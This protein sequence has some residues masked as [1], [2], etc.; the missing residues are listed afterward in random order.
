MEI[1]ENMKKILERLK[2]VE[3][4]LQQSPST[5]SIITST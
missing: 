1:Q 2:R 5:V 4:S 3:T